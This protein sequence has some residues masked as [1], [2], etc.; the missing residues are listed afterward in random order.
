VILNSREKRENRTVRYI[1]MVYDNSV[2]GCIVCYIST[3]SRCLNDMWGED[4]E[5][6][7]TTIVHNDS[8]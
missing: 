6:R 4:S 8:D 5:V 2:H 7:N 1:S 3:G